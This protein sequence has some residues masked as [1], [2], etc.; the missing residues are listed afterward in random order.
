MARYFIER[1]AR[2]EVVSLGKAAFITTG[3]VS[4]QGQSG[5]VSQR[6]M[7]GHAIGTFFGPEFAGVNDAYLVAAGDTIR[8][9]GQQL[10]LCARTAADCIDGTTV[11]PN[12]ADYGVPQIRQRTFLV[13][14]RLHLGSCEQ[15]EV[16]PRRSDQ[17]LTLVVPHRRRGQPGPVGHVPHGEQ[18]RRLHAQPLT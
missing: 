17:P 5:Q 14:E 6:I 4:G 8:R 2:N 3:N 18:V 10:F 12:A 16:R 1:L 7:P 9:P 15:D 11:T 13:G